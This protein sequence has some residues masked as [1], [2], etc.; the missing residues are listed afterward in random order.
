MIW[1]QK[2]SLWLPY[3]HLIGAFFRPHHIPFNTE[4]DRFLTGMP[5]LTKRIP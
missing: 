5:R 3:L 1:C 4:F 2:L